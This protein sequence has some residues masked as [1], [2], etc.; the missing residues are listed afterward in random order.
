M[1]N[2]KIP[3]KLTY[4]MD[5]IKIAKSG[6]AVVLKSGMLTTLLQGVAFIWLVI[7]FNGCMVGGQFEQPVVSADSIYPNQVTADS[8][9]NISWF[10]LYQDTV[11]QRLIKTALDSNRNLLTAAA[12][13]EE[14]R[15]IAGVVKANLYPSVGYQL[16]AGYGDA[17]SSAQQLGYLQGGVFKGFGTLDW[18]VD[19]WGKLRHAKRAAQSDFLAQEENRL[20]LQ[21]S[22]VSE[23]ASNYFILRDLDYRLQIAKRTQISRNENT[24]IITARFDTG[25]VSELDKLQAEQQEYVVAGAVPEFER[26]ITITENSLRVLL[27]MRPG[28]INRGQTN[29][30]QVFV[31]QIPSGLPSELLLRR[32]DIRSVN[33]QMQAQ[34]D[35]VGV[36]IANRFPSLNLTGL[37]GF[38]SPELNTFFGASGFVAAGGAG[39]FGPLFNFGKLKHATK[40]EQFRLQQFTYQYQQ[41]VL[42][43]FS[44]VDNSLKNY[45]S[46]TQQY[47]IVRLQVEAARKALALSEA[48]YN[49]GYT[50]YTE[51]VLQQ[52]NLYNAELN[53]SFILQSK[54]NAIVGLYRSLGGGF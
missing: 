49:F 45:Q 5:A 11:L 53:E 7:L 14:A 50:D 42:E 44:D 31:P 18:E 41:T 33:L 48:R 39:L 8:M 22:L 28:P 16:S 6:N 51:V 3:S 32:P 36:S 21:V 12:R 9:T 38:A 40:A 23:V 19:L 37:L 1:K 24:R 29:V 25:Y 46:Y 54:L 15:E 4:S 26:L 27:G 52:D 13:V 20:A 2:E 30:E 10:A 47:E 43:A 34:F 35:R 17:G